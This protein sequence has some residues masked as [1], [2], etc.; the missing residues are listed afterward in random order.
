MS[1]I[2][3]RCICSECGKELVIGR[4]VS[5]DGQSVFII[6]NQIDKWYKQG[7]HYYCPECTKK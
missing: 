2:R 3:I 5:A 7:R 1:Q 6:D 4:L